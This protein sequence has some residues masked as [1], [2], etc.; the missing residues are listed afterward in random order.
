VSIHE[1]LEG[2]SKIYLSKFKIYF[3]ESKHKKGYSSMKKILKKRQFSKSGGGEESTRHM[4][5][6]PS[7]DATVFFFC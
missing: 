6:C 1:N 4:L 3:L 7:I 5:P 2:G